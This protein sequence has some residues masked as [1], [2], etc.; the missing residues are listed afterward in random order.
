MRQ[1]ITHVLDSSARQQ[2]ELA[3]LGQLQVREGGRIPL[4]PHLLDRNRNGS[5][6]T[7]LDTHKLNTPL[8]TPL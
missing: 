7:A 8:P 2:R 3:G 1:E 5:R 4:H 6:Q